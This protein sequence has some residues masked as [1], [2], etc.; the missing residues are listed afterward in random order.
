MSLAEPSQVIANDMIMVEFQS[1]A[2]AVLEKHKQLD[3]DEIW[4]VRRE[5]H[6]IL[7]TLD[8]WEFFQRVGVSN[9]KS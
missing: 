5:C 7:S 8:G 4:T 2:H 9:V 6:D 3:A 1:I